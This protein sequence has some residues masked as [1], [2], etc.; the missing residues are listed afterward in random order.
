MPGIFTYKASSPYDD[1]PGERYHFPRAYLS[2]VERL[3]G[4]WIAFH[5]LK[6]RG[7]GANGYVSFARV[8]RID[9]DPE[10][11]DHFYARLSS[12]GTFAAPVPVHRPDRPVETGFNPQNAVRLIDEA[13]FRRLLS[14]AAGQDN[15][16]A[17]AAA[18]GLAEEQAP[19]ERPVEEILRQQRAGWFRERVLSAYDRRCALTAMR[20]VNGGGASEVEAA[21]IKPVADGGPDL[22]SNGIALTR[23]VHW[24]F[25]RH[26]ITFDDECRLLRTSLLS[27]EANAFLGNVTKLSLPAR[28]SDWPSP[29]FLAVHRERTLAKERA[30]TGR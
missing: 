23:T 22:V 11:P 6:D 3:V 12:A 30:K 28:R 1:V 25:D 4:D 17:P 19:L 18:P 10:R 2:R 8:E 15:Q 27:P 16:D 9:P 14:F 7:R 20:L 13:A 29:A 24:M 5:E 21:H 26:L